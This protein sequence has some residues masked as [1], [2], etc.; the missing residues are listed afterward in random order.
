MDI[1]TL[2]SFQTS[3]TFAKFLNSDNALT[4]LTEIEKHF[5]YIILDHYLDIFIAANKIRSLYH[6]ELTITK[7]NIQEMENCE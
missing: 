4:S 1:D 6:F 7:Q 5:A 2:L 3:D